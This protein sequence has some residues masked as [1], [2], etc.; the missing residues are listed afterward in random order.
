MAGLLSEESGA[1]EI[2]LE[3]GLVQQ[4]IKEF[5]GSVTPLLDFDAALKKKLKVTPEQCLQYRA[6]ITQL[7]KDINS[8]EQEVEAQDQDI[9]AISDQTLQCLDAE[10]YPEAGEFQ[11]GNFSEQIYTV[12]HELQMLSSLTGIQF[13]D[14]TSTV[15]RKEQETTVILKSLSGHSHSLSFDVQMEVEENL[16]QDQYSDLVRLTRGPYGEEI[17]F[18][19]LQDPGACF[20]ITCLVTLTSDPWKVIPNVTLKVKAKN[21][22]TQLDEKLT[23]QTCGEVFQDMI[24]VLGLE[25]AIHAIIRTATLQDNVHTPVE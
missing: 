19:K 25:Q 21:Q 12:D 24:K 22:M 4:T 8:L 20:I 15:I 9:L 11:R 14:N 1:E 10:L 2:K 5:P 3:L 7:Q 23:L 16:V 6:Q 18:K 13:H 17:E